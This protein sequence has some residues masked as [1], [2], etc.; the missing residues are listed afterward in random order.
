MRFVPAFT[1]L[2]AATLLAAGCGA[3]DPETGLVD[4]LD[5]STTV[6]VAN[7]PQTLTTGGPQRVLVA[8][9]GEG[10]NDFVGGPDLPATIE[11][12]SAEG[13]GS[14]EVAGEWVSNAG[15]ALGL[16]VAPFTF[17]EPGLWEVRIK[18]AGDDVAGALV[19][20][21]V[22]SVVPAAGDPAPPSIT[23]TGGSAAELAEISTDP[24]PD[25]SFYDLTIQDA[26]TNGEPAVIVF[27]TPAFC[28]TAICGPTLDT[29]KSATDD[30]DGVDVVHVEPFEIAQ[31]REGELVPIEAMFDWGLVTEPWVFV[32]DDAGFVTASFEGVIGADEL[33]RA[34]AD[35]ES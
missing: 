17:D 33:D 10:P 32:V 13:D 3:D 21:G 31:A 19:D 15:I 2:V 24:D 14:G 26:V 7:S 12:T 28:R 30:H 9:V 5:E 6:V 16:Y 23:P 34:I 1:A 27:A 4:E 20:V 11:F 29:V 25:P 8:V 35:V 18:G 22:D